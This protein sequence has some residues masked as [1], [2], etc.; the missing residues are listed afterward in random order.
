M[1]LENYSYSITILTGSWYDL[2]LTSHMISSV[3]RLAYSIQTFYSYVY[4]MHSRNDVQN[5]FIEVINQISLEILRR[6]N[7]GRADRDL[8]Y[9]ERKNEKEIMDVIDSGYLF[10]YGTEGV[11]GF[12]HKSLHLL[13]WNLRRNLI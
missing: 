2:H 13:N 11:D 6:E 7:N 3:F 5:A 9:S 4:G 8:M 1:F 10:R 12:Q